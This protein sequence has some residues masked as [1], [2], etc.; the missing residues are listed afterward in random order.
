MFFLFEYHKRKKYDERSLPE[1]KLNNLLNSNI[2]EV[3]L[4]LYG[5]SVSE[6]ISNDDKNKKT[7][8]ELIRDG[9]RGDTRFYHITHSAYYVDIYYMYTLYILSANIKVNEI[10]LPINLRN[11]SPQWDY[12][13]MFQCMSHI[14]SLIALLKNKN[15]I[16][17]N[18]QKYTSR[19]VYEFFK[20][21]VRY[22][23]SDYKC[24]CDFQNVIMSNPKSETDKIERK[25]DIFVYHYMNVIDKHHHKFKP[26]K[27][28]FEL[29]NKN[30][31]K[32]FVYLTPINFEGG[33][34]FVGKAFVDNLR[35][36]ASTVSG[37]LLSVAQDDSGFLTFKDFSMLL[38]SE[39]FFNR[40]ETTEHLNEDGRK[41]LAENIIK[42]R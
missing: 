19:T 15:I 29:C 18:V 16:I 21:N 36:N 41:L 34:R 27:D 32:L 3:D 8:F 4:L 33:E 17:D 12:N 11:F 10:I 24:V 20:S 31:I 38:T 6:R 2:E 35:S 5:D 7:L 26:L 40:E 30:M 28:L 42:L 13:P 14:N 25:K 37:Q 1:I 22:L 39:Y 9:L 23:G